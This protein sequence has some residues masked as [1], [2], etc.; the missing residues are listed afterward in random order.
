[1][2]ISKCRYIR[3]IFPLTRAS[4][5]YY[6]QLITIYLISFT[7]DHPVEFQESPNPKHPKGSRLWHRHQAGNRSTTLWSEH[8]P[9]RTHTS[10]YLLLYKCSALFTFCTADHKVDQTNKI[11]WP[12]C[13]CYLYQTRSFPLCMVVWNWPLQKSNFYLFQAKFSYKDIFEGC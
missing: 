2:L 11:F 4:G 13:E 7:F 9:G 8:H 3:E 1:M 6:G 10:L 5:D 12:D